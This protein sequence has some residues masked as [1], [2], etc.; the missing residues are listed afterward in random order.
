MAVDRPA[1]ALANTVLPR[2]TKDV[3][4]TNRVRHADG[5]FRGEE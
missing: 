2:S 3:R 5:R 4:V 1:V